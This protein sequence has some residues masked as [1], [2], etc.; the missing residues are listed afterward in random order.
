MIAMLPRTALAATLAVMLL[1]VGGCAAASPNTAPEQPVSVPH[2]SADA[3][4]DGGTDSLDS[5][6]AAGAGAYLEYSDGVIA[7]NPTPDLAT[8]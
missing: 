1:V 8:S 2:G 5:D 6:G 4:G 3:S 7:E